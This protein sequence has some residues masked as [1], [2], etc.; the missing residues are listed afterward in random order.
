MILQGIS[1]IPI[2][3]PSFT[4]AFE[5]LPEM[6]ASAAL[7]K[8]QE[9][10]TETTDSWS[11]EHLLTAGQIAALISRPTDSA[12]VVTRI[13]YWTREGLLG[14]FGD[15][16]HTGVGKHR[17]Y[18][19]MAVLDALVLNTLAEAGIPPVGRAG[20]LLAALA[21]ARAALKDWVA[22]R[23][24]RLLLELLPA[25]GGQTF[26][27]EAA[28]VHRLRKDSARPPRVISDA[29][30]SITIDLNKIFARVPRELVE[31]IE[32]EVAAERAARGEG[33]A[34]RPRGKK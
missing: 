30:V 33:K 32:R 14:V 27:G 20:A 22:D 24:L 9:P 25:R 17:Q 4:N 6:P 31:L 12:S 15:S 11:R 34:K 3:L 19:A 28:L 10:E 5:V 21:Q 23:K 29:E 26:A 16:V 2:V 1:L 18:E 7:P 13:R 8:E